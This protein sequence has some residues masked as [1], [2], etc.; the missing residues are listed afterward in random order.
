[1]SQPHKLPI[2]LEK[3]S[4]QLVLRLGIDLFPINCPIRPAT[5]LDTGSVLFLKLSYL[6]QFGLRVH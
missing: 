4:N 6:Q 5:F 3:K 1:M 2:L